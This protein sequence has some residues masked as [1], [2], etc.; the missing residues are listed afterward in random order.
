MKRMLAVMIFMLAMAVAS[1]SALAVPFGADGGSA[2]QGVL[3]DIT[4][5]PSGDSSIDVTT[6]FLS[7]TV[8]SRW[9]VTGSGGSIS[10][11][12]IELAGF[13]NANTFGVYSGTTYVELFDGAA[14]AGDQR[15][16]GIAND[17]SVFVNFTDTGL[18]FSSNNF[19]FYLISPQGTF[20]SETDRNADGVDHMLA[21]QGNDSDRI[22]IDP[23]FDGIWT[24]SEFILAF[25]D[26]WGG[27]DRDYTDFVVMVESV[28]PVPEP[29]TLL[30]LGGGLVG[31]AYLRKRKKA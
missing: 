28:N 11:L 17:G 3:D 9:E 5:T 6:D 24:D 15:S 4:V 27:G 7:D 25:E 22:A 14:S 20:H 12:V 30:L 21:Y 26:L 8:D 29:G 18:D 16:L 1:G 19:G 10:T 2:L 23:W 31:L 13:A